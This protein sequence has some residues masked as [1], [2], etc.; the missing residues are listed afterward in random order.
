MISFDCCL[1]GMNIENGNENKFECKYFVCLFYL[2]K[3]VKK[4]ETHTHKF[5][6]IWFGTYIDNLFIYLKNSS[7]MD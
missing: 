7:S 5:N 1:I 4:R 6:C 2:K 3:Q